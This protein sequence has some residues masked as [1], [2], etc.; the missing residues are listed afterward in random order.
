[1]RPGDR[2]RVIKV[3]SLGRSTSPDLTQPVQRIE[4]RL[5][6]L[7]RG[8][9]LLVEGLH[10]EVLRTTMIESITEGRH[11]TEVVT[12][13]SVYWVEALWTGPGAAHRRPGTL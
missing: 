10:G 7:E 2:V 5:R 8:C 4:G 6:L 11:G 9:P 13:H 1:M 12:L 3:R